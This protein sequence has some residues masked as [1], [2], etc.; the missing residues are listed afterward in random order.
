MSFYRHFAR[1]HSTLPS[2]AMMCGTF[3]CSTE[4]LQIMPELSH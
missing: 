2:L 3:L 4:S 1:L